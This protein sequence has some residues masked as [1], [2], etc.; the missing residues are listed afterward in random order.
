VVDD[1]FICLFQQDAPA[2]TGADGLAEKR[3][4]RERNPTLTRWERMLGS[5]HVRLLVVGLTVVA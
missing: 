1:G 5:S 3:E 4:E 2:G